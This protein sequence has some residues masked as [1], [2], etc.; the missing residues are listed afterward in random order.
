MS[1]DHRE[2][3]NS[4]YGELI[5]NTKMLSGEGGWGRGML[6]EDIWGEE[7]RWKETFGTSLKHGQLCIHMLLCSFPNLHEN[8]TED[9]RSKFGDWKA[10]TE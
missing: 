7:V 4:G 2:P 3:V 5:W 8:G 6:T 9:N 10:D 1:P